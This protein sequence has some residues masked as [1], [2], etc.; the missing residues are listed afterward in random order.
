MSQ[1]VLLCPDWL[2][3]LC[4]G[5]AAPNLRCSRLSPSAF[6]SLSAAALGALA[7]FSGR[8]PVLPLLNCS[9]VRDGFI[10]PGKLPNRCFWHV[11][12]TFGIGC[13]FRVGNCDEETLAPP[14]E[15]ESRLALG[16]EEPPVL[17]IDLRTEDGRGD[18]KSELAKLMG[19]ELRRSSIVLIKLRLPKSDDVEQDPLQLLEPAMRQARPDGKLAD[20][21]HRFARQCPELVDRSK[22]R[23]RECTN[24]C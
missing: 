17:R 9:G 16:R 5:V 7:R 24:T 22:Q 14:S 23:K 2:A 11:H 15:L 4:L 19:D 6:A 13:S 18:I 8:T 20:A 10:F 21:M 3:A 12:T 1:Q